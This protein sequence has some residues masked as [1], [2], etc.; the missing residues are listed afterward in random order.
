MEDA[1]FEARLVRA[2]AAGELA[3]DAR[4]ADLAKLATATLNGMAVRA[5]SGGDVAILAGFGR[6]LAETICGPA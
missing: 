5:R 4:R 2:R 6:G 3:P 1:A